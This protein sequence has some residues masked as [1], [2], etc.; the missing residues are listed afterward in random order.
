MRV[1]R[2]R[3][4]SAAAALAVLQASACANGGS[5]DDGAVDAGGDRVGHDAAPSFYDAGDQPD[6]PVSFYDA[7]VTQPDSGAPEA[8]NGVDSAAGPDATGADSGI[9]ETGGQDVTAATGLTVL[10]SVGDASSTSAY[11]GCTLSV[12]NGGSTPVDVSSLELRYYY[13]AEDVAGAKPTPQMTIQ[14]SHVSTSSADQPLSVTSAFNALSPSAPTA[15]AYVAFDLSSGH[16]TLAPGEAAVFSWQ[17]QGPNPATDV[18]DQTK[19]YSFSPSMSALTPWAHVTLYQS[20]ALAW[21][22]PP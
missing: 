9:P 13:T 8:P 14:W 20:G 19:D 3:A 2:I 5:A 11:I 7:P 1:R 12:S 15:D 22:N 6:T 4:A 17:M 10:Y 21:G 16:S 18:Y